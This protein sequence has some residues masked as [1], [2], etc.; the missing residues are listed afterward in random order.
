MTIEWHKALQ[1]SAKLCVPQFCLII[2]II[3]STSLP[4]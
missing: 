1:S 3:P 4:S 2:K